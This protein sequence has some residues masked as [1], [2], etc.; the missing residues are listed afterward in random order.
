MFDCFKRD[1]GGDRP[2]AIDDLPLSSHRSSKR[3]IDLPLPQSTATHS[4]TDG[5]PVLRIAGSSCVVSGQAFLSSFSSSGSPGQEIHAPRIV[6][7]LLP[8]ST[9]ISESVLDLSLP[10]S[11]SCKWLRLQPF[12]ANDAAKVWWSTPDISEIAKSE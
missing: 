9:A 11:R 5:V 4:S 2:Q 3:S 1:K 10:G 6:C 12:Y 7:R 8:Q